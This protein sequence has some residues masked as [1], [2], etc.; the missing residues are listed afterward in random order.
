MIPFG[1][2]A[3]AFQSCISL[4]YFCDLVRGGGAWDKN[5]KA[6][7]YNWLFCVVFNAMPAIWVPYYIFC[8]QSDTKNFTWLIFLDIPLFV[9][10]FAR[11]FLLA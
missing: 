9:L 11:P 2:A 7:A 3:C 4:Y 1:I 10:T 8:A 6:E 5:R